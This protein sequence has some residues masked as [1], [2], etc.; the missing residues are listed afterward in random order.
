VHLSV[1][2][3]EYKA[4]L[5][6]LNIPEPYDV[7][8]GDEWLQEHKARLLLKIIIIIIIDGNHHY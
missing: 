4:W 1:G 8:F 3:Y 2:P 7:L 5:L 6:V